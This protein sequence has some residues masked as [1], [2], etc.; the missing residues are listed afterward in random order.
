M[1]A[2]L[3][4][5][6][7]AILPGWVGKFHDA[8][9]AYRQYTGG[10]QSLPEVL[11]GTVAGRLMDG[12]LILSCAMLGWRARHAPEGSQGFAGETAFV[13]AVTVVIVPMVALYNQILLIPALLLLVRARNDLHLTSRFTRPV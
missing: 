3:F 9:V 10:G 5:G 1:T 8:V 12:V 6:S 13:L 11:L 2:V 7:Y 4:A